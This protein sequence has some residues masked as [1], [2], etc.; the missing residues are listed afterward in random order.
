MPA[1]PRILLRPVVGP[2]SHCVPP[3]TVVTLA[4]VRILSVV[5]AL[6]ALVALPAP[7]LAGAGTGAGSAP[8]P[9]ITPA[10]AAGASP[11]AAAAPTT[12]APTATAPTG[13]PTTTTPP[14]TGPVAGPA[15]TLVL[16]SAVR[17][18]RPVA[19]RVTVGDAPA[20]GPIRW[21]LAQR[22]HVTSVQTP[23]AV[24]RWTFAPGHAVVRADLGA[25]SARR[26]ILVAADPGAIARAEAHRASVRAAPARAIGR[27][28]VLAQAASGMSVTIRDFSFAPP[29]ITLHAG[30][31]ITWRN[32][33]KQPHTA[34]AHDG[35]FNTGTLNTGQSATETFA[36]AGTFKYICSIHPF[37]HGTVTVLATASAAKPAPGKSAS[38]A[39]ASTPAATASAAPK[40]TAPADSAR[41]AL[42]LTGDLPLVRAAIGAALLLLGLAVR[43]QARSRA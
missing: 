21:T 30:Q 42:P 11:P 38:P 5:A 17:A 28:V 41:P 15:P 20:Q 8:G 1:P 36:H 7:A 4:S 37:M 10:T 22:A 13:P 31:T 18:G 6:T 24:L 9:G 33:G 26:R 27:P 29:S 39:K 25:G 43:R 35:S 23:A 32:V 14:A 40:A 19:L 2:K 16:S 12:T 3:L 34:T